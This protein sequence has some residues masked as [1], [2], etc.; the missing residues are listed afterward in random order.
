MR[1][2]T[3]LIVALVVVGLG[4]AGGLYYYYSEGTPRSALM[5]I[6]LAIQTDDKEKLFQ[7]IDMPAII[8]ALA[9]NGS[10]DI[11]IFG[12]SGNE[13]QAPGDDMTR[14]GRALGKKLSQYLVPKM[15]TVLEPQIK[16]QVGAYLANLGVKEKV[17]LA[18]VLTNA[19]IDQQGDLANVTVGDANCG[20][21]FKFQMARD[22]QVRIWRIVEVNYQDLKRYL[23][24]ALR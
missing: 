20:H 18:G 7:Y 8:G 24:R 17:A 2:T 13:T 3:L 19:T 1:K 16:E 6:V 21:Q 15:I 9:A 23:Q 5:Q 14:L 11:N 22:P 12:D 4:L 10:E